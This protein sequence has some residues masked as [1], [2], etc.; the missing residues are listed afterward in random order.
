VD[1]VFDPI[2]SGNNVD[3]NLKLFELA[4]ITGAM[5]IV[6][7][8][9]RYGN[10]TMVFLKYCKA[11]GGILQSVDT[12]SCGAT[13]RYVEIAGLQDYWEFHQMNDLKWKPTGSIDLVFIDTTHVFAHTLA[14]LR[15]FTVYSSIV[16]FHDTR[17][18]PAVFKAMKTWWRENREW[19]F[20]EGPCWG[21]SDRA[22]YDY[23]YGM[24]IR[25]SGVM[26]ILRNSPLLE[27]EVVREYGP[28][29]AKLDSVFEVGKNAKSE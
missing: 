10:S 23:G 12:S 17:Y 20:L 21:M 11:Y 29:V 7:C 27:L 13:K 9:V 15:K 8:G 28:Q 18:T 5:N 19:S 4:R 14:E 1:V 2:K 6:E 26:R 3:Y 24:M 16:A 22:F 25:D